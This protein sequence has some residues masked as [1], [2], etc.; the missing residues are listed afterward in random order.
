MLA[1]AS[2]Y[3]SFAKICIL[4]LCC[5]A[6]ARTQT[7]ETPKPPDQSDDV[8]RVNTELIQT[9][10][11]VFDRQGRFVT[12][13]AR[14]NFELRIDGKPRPIGFFDRIQAGT[15]SEERQLAAARGI[16]TG[17]NPSQRAVAPLDRGRPVFFFIDDLHMSSSSLDQARKLLTK[18]IDYDLKQNDEAEV[19]SASGQL[20]FLQQ[21]T[22]NK[23]V[24]HTATARLLARSGAARD[25]QRPPMGEYQ[26]LQ[27]DR[28]DRD[29]LGFFADQLIAENRMMSRTSAED[30]V[31]RRASMILEQAAFYTTTM[32][33]AL[34][35]LVRSCAKLPGRKVI[36]LISDGFFIDPRHSDM[37]ERMRL[38]TS[39]AARSGA[40]I[41]SIDARGLIATVADASTPVAADTTGRLSRGGMGEIISSQ[42]GLNALAH[43]TGGRALFNTNDL[44]LAVQSGLKET[45][46]YYLLAWRP[47]RDAN[48]GSKFRRLEVAVVGR[49]ELTVRVRR[50]FFDLEP[51]VKA[52]GKESQDQKAP[53]QT[54]EARLREAIMAPVAAKG[55]P[56][57]MSLNYIDTPQKGAALTVSMMVPGE[58]LSFDAGDKQLAQVDLAGALFNDRG[59]ATAQFGE[60]ITLNAV[61]STIKD[62][63]RELTYSRTVFLAP[64][65]Y[66]VRAAVRDLNSEHVGSANTWI[67]IPDLSNHKLALSSLLLGER[68]R[69]EAAEAAVPVS[70]PTDTA[71]LSIDGRFNR[72]SFL[73]YLIFIY[74]AERAVANQ[75]PDVVV[76]IQILRDGQPVATTTLK[77][78]PIDGAQDL[79]RL[80]YAADLPL[81]GFPAGRY[82]LLFTAIDRVAKTKASQQIR[83]EID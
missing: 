64:G 28:G 11:M 34:D 2:M 26:A 20:G 58:F 66:Q 46:V 79:Q 43:D 8:V 81:D 76:Q 14:E 1:R 29:L 7:T 42:D 67:E 6:S 74:N 68:P 35:E 71:R 45:S 63:H 83:F 69:S 10:V 33:A 41:Y 18:F 53:P 17:S 44:H 47:D 60:R 75:T 3:K 54:A 22:D 37:T 49:P 39:A 61:T 62:T 48:N 52:K 32:L 12:D 13:L 25:L 77:K 36:F 27:V 59:I 56:L 16:A 24:L 23:T 82:V 78:V 9:D 30:E 38:L 70:S 50:G 57:S 51:A 5:A 80:S 4:L 21:L 55:I 31:R 15:A 19:A 65:L 40:I 73:R 72:G